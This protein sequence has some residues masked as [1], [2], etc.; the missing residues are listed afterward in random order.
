MT[1]EDIKAALFDGAV[2]RVVGID[3]VDTYNV[4]TS[5]D[6]CSLYAFCNDEKYM[7]A[8]VFAAIR[9]ALDRFGAR[10]FRC[11]TDE[12]DVTITIIIEIGDEC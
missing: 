7:F 4:T 6:G 3:Y 5:S 1:V 2:V 11:V 12:G 8:D 10:V 9:R